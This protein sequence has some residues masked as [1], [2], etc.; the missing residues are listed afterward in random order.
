MEEE[1]KYVIYNGVRVVDY[2]PEQI[3]L[4]QKFTTIVL[5]GKEFPRIKYGSESDDWGADSHP[6]GDCAVLKEQ[7]HVQSCDI[8]ECPCCGGQLLSCDCEREV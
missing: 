7:F 2:W 1:I 6:C 3:E 5:N 8:E 4:A